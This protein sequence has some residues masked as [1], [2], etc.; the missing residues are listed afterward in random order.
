MVSL[1]NLFLLIF[2]VGVFFINVLLC[3]MPAKYF[4]PECRSRQLLGTRVRYTA[5]MAEFSVVGALCACRS[6]VG[7]NLAHFVVRCVGGNLC[8]T[9]AVGA[10]SLCAN[11]R[12]KRIL[13]HSVGFFVSSR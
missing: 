6:V 13:R 7:R 10:S 2:V 1:F 5:E 12:S 11:I 3:S 8:S 4:K 9:I